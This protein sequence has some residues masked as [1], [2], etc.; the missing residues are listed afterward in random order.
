MEIGDIRHVK[1]SRKHYVC[2]WCY[3]N[4]PVGSKYATWFTYGENVTARLHPE[5][6]QASIRADLYGEELPIAGTFRRG[7]FCGEN[8]EHCNCKDK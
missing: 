3:H 8:I 5:C 4:I 2:D 6:Y 7:C 1:K